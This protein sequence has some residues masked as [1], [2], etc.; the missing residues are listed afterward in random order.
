MTNPSR[1]RVLT[2]RD[3]G[4]M[5]T[6]IQRGETAIT[7]A[8]QKSVQLTGVIAS[9]PQQVLNAAAPALANLYMQTQGVQ[10]AIT[11]A[12]LAATTLPKFRST[13]TVNPVAPTQAEL[14]AN[15]NGIGG[16]K[17]TADGGTQQLVWTPHTLAGAWT[18]IGAPSATAAQVQ[19]AE[20]NAAASVL[21]VQGTQLTREVAA[22]YTP[23]ATTTTL[24][25]E[26]APYTVENG[27][28]P[29]HAG[30][31]GL[32][33]PLA[34]GKHA[35]RITD[36]RVFDL[37]AWKFANGADI[38]P[39]LNYLLRDVALKKPCLILIPPGAFVLSEAVA[40]Y[41][42]QEVQGVGAGI[43]YLTG[44]G[45]E[46]CVWYVNRHANAASFGG[47][48]LGVTLTNGKPP[49]G[50]GQPVNLNGLK[51]IRIKGH[52][53]RVEGC[54]I[55]NFTQGLRFNDGAYAEVNGV[56]ND[57]QSYYNVV[58]NTTFASC[59]AAVQL[60]GAA[61]RND[62]GG[63]W[64]NND[65]CI[66]CSQPGNVSE[67]NWI[68][69]NMEG[70]KN[71]LLPDSGT[72]Y[73]QNWDV[74]VECSTAN[75][76]VCEFRD[77]GRQLFL[78]LDIVPAPRLNPLWDDPV[79][80]NRRGVRFVRHVEGGRWSTRLFTNGSSGGLGIGAVIDE[81]LEL[82]ATWDEPLN[83]GERGFMWSNVATGLLYGKSGTAPPN[84]DTDGQPLVASAEV[85]FAYDPPIIPPG[86]LAQHEFPI[87]GAIVGDFLEVAKPYY[88]K[89]VIVDPD[90]SS[91]GNGV[92]TLFNP[93]GVEV[94][95]PAGNWAVKA[96]RR[97]G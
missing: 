5:D 34:G 65:Y 32:F 37:R 71:I 13:S 16:L 49:A 61:N 81:A 93:S 79:P 47:A 45:P 19:A 38:G 78:R 22:T 56:G 92:L 60:R 40:Q 77:P 84:N 4:T 59:Y 94:S 23:P 20:F 55:A 24:L 2:E 21:S 91:N 39:T 75:T 85:V 73:T 95:L 74:A 88:T 87:P 96:T 42:G 1:P 44:Q 6:L 82:R 31:G 27:V 86:G 69:G 8:E 35:K 28:V 51:G 53:F 33:L 46:E 97:R 9:V 30:R 70:N 72:V 14:D 58:R 52:G 36:G 68:R 67:H 66:D 76:H 50:V 64:T 25:I 18:A 12:Q 83:L 48:L 90:L 63:V 3:A 15:P 62:I 89:G 10:A 11:A 29:P 26:G 7:G 54:E 43:T 57:E 41:I 17:L 80:A